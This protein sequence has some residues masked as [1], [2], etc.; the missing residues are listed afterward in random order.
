MKVVK[1]LITALRQFLSK[2]IRREYEDFI[3]KTL[4]LRLS[5]IIMTWTCIE[6]REQVNKGHGG[7]RVIRKLIFTEIFI[8][9]VTVDVMGHL[10]PLSDTEI[11]GL[12]VSTTSFGCNCYFSY[13]FKA[14]QKIFYNETLLGHAKG[15]LRNRLNEGFFVCSSAS[16]KM[17]A[18]EMV[19]S[20]INT[21]DELRY[22]CMINN[23][24]IGRGLVV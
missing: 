1:L 22:F 5:N 7:N 15:E 11:K 24:P 6:Q 12:A 3:A 20:L 19:T 2:T 9:K 17:E 14:G 21:E 16:V 10:K 23:L 8:D 18:S 4:S 13:R